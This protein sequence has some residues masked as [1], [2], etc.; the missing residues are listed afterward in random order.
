MFPPPSQTFQGQPRL[1]VYR[2]SRNFPL[3]H[4]ASMVCLT[5]PLLLAFF[6]P[7]RSRIE[8]LVVAASSSSGI[9]QGTRPAVVRWMRDVG[10]P[11]SPHVIAGDL[12]PGGRER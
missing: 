2:R 5:T 11:V 9:Y 6:F 7:F 8:Q 1:S 3:H 12:A 4:F 10:K